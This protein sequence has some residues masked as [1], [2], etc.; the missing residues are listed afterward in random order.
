MGQ[1]METSS[2]R[3]SPHPDAEKIP[4]KVLDEPD[5]PVELQWYD[6]LAA[7]GGVPNSHQIGDKI[8]QLE[9]QQA[10]GDYDENLR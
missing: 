8:M 3:R 9:A 4:A 5:E 10:F 1:L 2:M 6:L 7:R